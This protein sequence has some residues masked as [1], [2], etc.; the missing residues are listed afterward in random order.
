MER[1]NNVINTDSEM[2]VVKEGDQEKLVNQFTLS[3]IRE[4][5]KHSMNIN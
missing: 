2:V 3:P 1:K 5:E 4:L